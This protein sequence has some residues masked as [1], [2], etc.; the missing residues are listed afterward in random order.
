MNASNQGSE[1]LM[2]FFHRL[3]DGDLLDVFVM[4]SILL[5]LLTVIGLIIERVYMI[6]F[7][8]SANAERLMQKIQ[9]LILDNNVDEAVKI[10][11]S[12]KQAV[13]YQVFKAA[14]VNAHRPFD[15]IQD[16][17]EVEKLG[18]VPKLQRRMPYL[19]TL[20]NVA[21]LLGLLGTVIGLVRTF[22]GVGALEASQ[23]QALLSS[24]ISTALNSTAYGLMVAIPCMLAYGFLFSRVN[25]IIDEVEHYSSKLLVL[26]RTGSEYFDHFSPDEAVTTQQIPKKAE[27][28]KKED[29]A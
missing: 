3:Q 1:I 26:L 20:G 17:V 2:G 5:M 24:G 18:L 27:P 25:N 22:S 7:V 10:C 12:K 29:V 8:Y 21:T 13:I 11:N 9:Q 6:L 16:F 15:E 4:G 23:K 28:G 19:F 14:L